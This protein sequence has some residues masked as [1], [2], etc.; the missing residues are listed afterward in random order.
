MIKDRIE[1]GRLL[2]Q[3]INFV[4]NHDVLVL[5][6]PRGGVIVGHEIAKKIGCKLDIAIS[7]KITP[8]D[9]PEFAIGAI[10]H[11]GTLFQSN[12]WDN[13]VGYPNLADEIEKKKL[14]VRRRL[15]EYRGNSEYDI[16]G[17]R[18]ILVDDG[19]ATGST[20]FAIL[21]WLTKQN[22]KEII[23]AI[24]VMPAGVYELMKQKASSVIAL[25]T[26]VEFSAVGQFYKN[27]E[28]VS[29]E[30]VIQVLSYY[31]S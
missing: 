14:E 18:I 10:T 25:D 29:D 30:E 12:Y 22:V 8:P 26:P 1:A 19:I 23:L 17:K 21:N 11:D 3:K 15:E 27:F 24:P 16:S 31:K 20:V 13:Y 9:S 2:A 5:A 28:Q 4:S 7:K 6:I